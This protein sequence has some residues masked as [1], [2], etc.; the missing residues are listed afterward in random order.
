[1]SFKSAQ[2]ELKLHRNFYMFNGNP[3]DSYAE[4]PGLD[5]LCKLLDQKDD[6]FD[7]WLVYELCGSPL[8]KLLFTTKG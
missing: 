6:K 1:M 7:L 3:Y 2:D 8:S 4:H 5:S